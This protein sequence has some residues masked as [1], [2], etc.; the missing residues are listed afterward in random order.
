MTE[1]VN[2]LVIGA[3][4]RDSLGWH[5]CHELQRT[6]YVQA[7]YGVVAA[8]VTQEPDPGLGVPYHRL[9]LKWHAHDV[10]AEL[11]KI[12]PYHIVNL[13]GRNIPDEDFTSLTQSVEAHHHGNLQTFVRLAEAW[14]PL[15]MPG[16]H[17]VAMSSNS[18]HIPRSPSL[19]YCVSKAAVSMAVR[20]LARKWAGVPL[21]YGYEPGLLATRATVAQASS[22]AYG[23]GALHR[24]RGVPQY[25]N[26]P[27][28]LAKL[29]G[30]NLLEGGM[31]LNG[32]ML[33]LDAGEL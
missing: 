5:L 3:G 26:E 25:G 21:V 30:H 1:W 24:M 11:K 32:C 6:P 9:D 23:A 13:A 31:H 22:G 4:S 16:S 14:R 17:L 33:R 15:A 7:G 12:R 29:I 27:K 10:S 8:D 2:I 18:A 19:G 20:V 28:V